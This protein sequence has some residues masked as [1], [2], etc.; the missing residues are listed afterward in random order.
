MAKQFVQQFDTA[1]LVSQPF[2]SIIITTYNR[3]NLIKRALNSLVSQTETDW[4][5]IIIDD[6]SHDDTY[7]QVLPYLRS[8]NNIRYFRIVHGGEATAKNEGIKLSCGRFITFLDSDDE[9][10]SIHLNSRKSILI[11]NPEVRFLYGGAIVLGNQF[12]PDRIDPT[13]KIELA[14]CVI[15]GTFFIERNSIKSL[16]G[17]KQILLGPDADLFDRAK[18]ARIAMMETK[19]P[20]YIYHHDTADSITNKMYYDE[21]S[22]CIQSLVE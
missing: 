1:F 5:A 19:L 21:Q 3:S 8:H 17:F 15:G 11:Q 12:V 9:Y 7:L 10:N 13:K 6:E 18:V 16:N 4:E 22:R 20:T 2:F 14:N